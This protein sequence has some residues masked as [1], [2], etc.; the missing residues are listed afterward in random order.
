VSH[1]V[2]QVV[3]HLQVASQGAGPCPKCGY[4]NVFMTY[5][6]YIYTVMPEQWKPTKRTMKLMHEAG[7][8]SSRP[9]LGYRWPAIHNANKPSGHKRLQDAL[10]MLT[11]PIIARVHLHDAKAMLHKD[12]VHEVTHGHACMIA[13]G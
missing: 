1:G 9:H 5:Y 2:A 13:G 12:V 10:Q 6:I 7:D 8:R 4:S 11:V 3:I